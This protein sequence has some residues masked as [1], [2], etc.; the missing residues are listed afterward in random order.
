MNFGQALEALK[1]GKRVYR[2]NWNGVGMWMELDIPDLFS[3]ANLTCIIYIKH[4]DGTR[5]PWFTSQ[6]E[7]LAEDWDIKGEENA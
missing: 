2:S 7:I 5:Y 6:T 3:I 4:P 1:Q